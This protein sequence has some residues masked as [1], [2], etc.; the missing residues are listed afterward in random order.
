MHDLTALGAALRLQIEWGAD[1]A[2]LESPVDRFAVPEPARQAMPGLAARVLLP[3]ARAPVARAL[4][5]SAAAAAQA[6]AARADDLA[7]LH[8]ALDASESPLRATASHTVGPA[9]NPHGGLV[10]IG[11]APGPDDDRSGQAYSGA[12]G[13]VLDRVLASAGLAREA[14]LLAFLVPWR[15]PGGRAPSEAE[16]GSCLPFM[17]RLLQL[18]RPRRVVLM[19]G[20][21]LRALAG[22]AS[23]I[24]RA[25]GKWLEI[26]VPGVAQP[27]PALAM[28][29]PELWLSSANNRSATWSGLMMLRAVLEN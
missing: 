12:T 20:L 16:I 10:L 11:E 17:H 2:L 3:A 25:Q 29:P 24:R 6:T 23:G 8:A 28:L 15:P 14:L 4:A 18:T 7:A 21:A 22:D 13:R 5:P 1:E 19:S 26:A 27:V 9:G